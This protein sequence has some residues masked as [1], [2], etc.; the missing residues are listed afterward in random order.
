MVIDALSVC[1]QTDSNNEQSRHYSFII[2]FYH[3]PFT[4]LDGICHNQRSISK[5]STDRL[6][7]IFLGDGDIYVIYIG[8]SLPGVKAFIF[9]IV[10]CLR[11]RGC[12]D[13]HQMQ[14]IRYVN[15]GIPDGRVKA[16]RLQQSQYNWPGPNSVREDAE[17]LENEC[18]SNRIRIKIRD[19]SNT[20]DTPPR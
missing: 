4:Q 10:F 1:Y 3:Q 11:V 20:H 17:E 15:S 9:N 5:I 2:L 16:D 12:D 18:R 14:E 7:F 19:V 13:R 6:R 8:L